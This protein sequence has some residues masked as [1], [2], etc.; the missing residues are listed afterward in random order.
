MK[1]QNERS[2]KYTYEELKRKYIDKEVPTYK[3]VKAVTNDYHVFISFIINLVILIALGGG[4]GYYL[5][6]KFDTKPIMMLLLI[7]LGIGAAFRNLVKAVTSSD[8]KGDQ[9]NDK[10]S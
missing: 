2:T 10:Q 6:Q 3:K 8:D 4:C 9:N 1:D 7:L 5:D